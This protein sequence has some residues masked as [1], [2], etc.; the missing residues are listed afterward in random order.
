MLI[1][2]SEASFPKIM[3]WCWKP[4]WSQASTVSPF[5]VPTGGISSQKAIVSVRPSWI[6]WTFDHS[7][8]PSCPITCL[9]WPQEAGPP[10]PPQ[11]LRQADCTLFSTSKTGT[12]LAQSPRPS[13]PL[14]LFPAE[15]VHHCQ[16]LRVNP[17]QLYGSVHPTSL[18]SPWCWLS[19]SIPSCWGTLWA[20][21]ERRVHTRV[22]SSLMP[23]GFFP[24]LSDPQCSL[25][26]ASSGNTTH[27]AA[28]WTWWIPRAEREAQGH[29]APSLGERKS[30]G[31]EQLPQQPWQLAADLKQASGKSAELW[32]AQRHWRGRAGTHLTV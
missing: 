18:S 6:S 29:E 20:L 25:W 21:G 4:P 13:E 16:L 8:V 12:T 28:S 30:L 5:P 14:W 32:A 15:S 3:R 9:E 31:A 17:I 7:L 26:A 19:T 11:D 22:S 27:D 23:L 1:S 10:A 2:S 24:P